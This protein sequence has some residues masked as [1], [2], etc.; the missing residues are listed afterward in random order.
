MHLQELAADA[1]RRDGFVLGWLNDSDEEKIHLLEEARSL[2]L[3]DSP[4][5]GIDALKAQQAVYQGYRQRHGVGRYQP[6]LSRKAAA[7]RFGRKDDY[8]TYAWTH[9][10]VHGSDAVWL[11]S[12]QQMA[13]DTFAFFGRNGD[14]KLAT[15]LGEF[16]AK[17]LV[18]AFTAI[19]EMLDWSG[20]ERVAVLMAQIKDAVDANDRP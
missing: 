13:D 8:W 2:G 5:A 3:E 16:A 10:A 20:S 19:N 11:F 14:A 15:I 9:E 7:V 6:F 17:S 4:E 18:A 12:R 1:L